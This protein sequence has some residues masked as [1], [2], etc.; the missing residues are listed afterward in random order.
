[1]RD[2]ESDEQR[3]NKS[4]RAA[5]ATF[6]CV[7]CVRVTWCVCLFVCLSLFFCLSVCALLLWKYFRFENWNTYAHTLCGERRY[8]SHIA[9][10]R[11]NSHTYMDYC[12]PLRLG[13]PQTNCESIACVCV[14]VWCTL[15]NCSRNDSHW[16]VYHSTV[17]RKHI[18]VCVLGILSTS[19]SFAYG[20]LLIFCLG[21]SA[22]D[23]MSSLTYMNKRA[24]TLYVCVNACR[25]ECE[26]TRNVNAYNNSVLWRACVFA[27]P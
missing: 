17:L 15:Q 13:S 22:S 8:R 12:I 23:F 9:I 19:S 6:D 7:I 11:I 14:C 2:I 5:Y 10:K 16:L 25:C 3:M 4:I 26:R 20:S 18:R 1:M 27:I 24:Q 21:C